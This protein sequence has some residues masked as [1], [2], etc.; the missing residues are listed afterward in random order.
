MSNLLQ[1]KSKAP[2]FV[3]YIELNGENKLIKFWDEFVPYTGEYSHGN[4]I[5]LEISDRHIELVDSLEKATILGKISEFSNWSRLPKAKEKLSD[6]LIKN[7]KT[8]NDIK[9]LKISYPEPVEET[10]SVDWD[11]I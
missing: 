8:F 7:N 9:I 4:W 1:H 2:E 3:L 6:L 11:I 10:V 5:P